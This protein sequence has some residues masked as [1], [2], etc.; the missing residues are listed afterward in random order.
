[1]AFACPFEEKPRATGIPERGTKNDPSFKPDFPYRW[2]H[3][4]GQSEIKINGHLKAKARMPYPTCLDA[5]D[6]LLDLTLSWPR[7]YEGGV[8]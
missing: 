6:T 5:P 8:N 1:M 2:V 3:P 4:R 7:K